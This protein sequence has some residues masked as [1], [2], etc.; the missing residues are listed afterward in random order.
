[1]EQAS[2]DLFGHDRPVVSFDTIAEHLEFVGHGWLYGLISG[3]FHHPQK[4][5]KIVRVD[6]SS[7]IIQDV[8]LQFHASD[9]HRFLADSL[10][11]VIRSSWLHKRSLI[12]DHDVAKSSSRIG[13]IGRGFSM[14]SSS[15]RRH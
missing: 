11:G 3:S 13:S 14:A 4:R 12:H 9:C 15:R 10:W 1:M 5:T 7:A 6:Y 8:N 2:A